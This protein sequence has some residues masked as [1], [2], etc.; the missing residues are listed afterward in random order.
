MYDYAV[1]CSPSTSTDSPEL[2]LPPVISSRRPPHTFD[3][4]RGRGRGRGSNIRNEEHVMSRSCLME[5]PVIYDNSVIDD[6][7]EIS[8]PVDLKDD[9]SS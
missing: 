6:Q 4:M 5:L 8:F 7:F 3:R 1:D 2:P 9:G